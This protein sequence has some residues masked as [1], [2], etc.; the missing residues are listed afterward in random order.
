MMSNSPL[1]RDPEESEP[2]VP[3]PSDLSCHG[4]SIAAELITQQPAPITDK[5][6]LIPASSI[7]RW[8]YQSHVLSMGN[9]RIFEFGAVL[10]LADI[11]PDTLL[12]V[13]VYA[14]VRA[15]S[16]ICFS[17]SLGR[18]IDRRNRLS[19]VRFSIVGQRTAVILSC[20]LLGFM[21]TEI[22]KYE[23]LM[24][25][26]L[27]LLCLL[28]CVEKLCAVMNL[29]AIERDWVV[30]VAENTQHE[31][32]TLNSQMRRIDLGCKLLGPLIVALADALSTR[33]AILGTLVL[34]LSSV[35]VEYYTITRVRAVFWL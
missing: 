13:S 29:I 32:Q 12:P 7:K 1:H 5:P 24:G 17:P 2:L 16:A 20:L 28:A 26:L 23:I 30:V 21:T 6:E 3:E 11:F 27:G 14:F 8:L 19:I 10:F 31:L 25:G 22:V 34:S 35:L 4:E 9:S 33:A 18:L 15:A